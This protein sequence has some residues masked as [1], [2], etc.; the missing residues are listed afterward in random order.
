MEWPNSDNSYLCDVQIT[1]SA[2]TIAHK[3]LCTMTNNIRGHSF[4][5]L[6]IK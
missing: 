1:H 4:R 2:N 5:V 6:Y 3:S